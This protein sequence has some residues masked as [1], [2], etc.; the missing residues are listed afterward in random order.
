MFACH[1]DFNSIKFSFF[2]CFEGSKKYALIQRLFIS[3]Q[4]NI[5]WIAKSINQNKR[6]K[7][8]N[9]ENIK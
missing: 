5:S 4:D 8:E 3:V 9:T 6:K 2:H 1:K 7:E